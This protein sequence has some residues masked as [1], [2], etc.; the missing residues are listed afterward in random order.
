M[1][2]I[3]V[4]ILAFL[5]LGSTAFASSTRDIYAD[6]LL[7]ASGTASTGVPVLSTGT[8][9]V[10]APGTSGN[11]LTSNG[12][13]WV[14]S[15]APGAVTPVQEVPSGTVNGSNTSFS[16]AFTPSAAASVHLTLDGLVLIQGS[17]QDYTISGST[18]TMTTAP[19]LGQKLYALYTK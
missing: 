17:G 12:T 4:T 13:T 18:I 1:A 19:A 2:K 15:A 11:V 3:H 5:L 8:I 10:V 6:R 16:L 9:S 14:S 7:S